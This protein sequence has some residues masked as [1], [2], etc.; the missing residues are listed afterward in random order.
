M[1]LNFKI[2]SIFI[3]LPL[4]LVF[5]AEVLAFFY[6]TISSM[7]KVIICITLLFPFWIK[8]KLPS[9]FMGFLCFFLPFF[10]FSFFNSFSSAAAMEEGVR[11]IF[12]IAILVYGYYI[13]SNLKLLVNS[14]VVFMV[15]NFVYQISN[16]VNYYIFDVDSQWFY[17]HHYAEKIDRHFY[18]PA[19][20]GGIMRATGLVGFFAAFGILNFVTYWL[21]MYYYNGKYKKIILLISFLGVFLS[22]SFKAIGFFILT[23]LIKFW[24]RIKYLLVLPIILL[25]SYLLIGDENRQTI[26]QAITA[27]LDF[28][29]TEGNSARSESYRVMFNEIKSFNM[30]GEGLGSFGGPASTKY[31]SPFYEKVNFNWYGLNNLDTTDTYFPHLFVEMGI[32]GGL[33]YLFLILSPII[34]KKRL[35]LKNAKILLILYGLL[36]IDSVFSYSLNNLAILSMTLLFVYPILKYKDDLN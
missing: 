23:L 1:K 13:R 34:I 26:S 10:I 6:P 14:L 11:Y 4:I 24:Y 20:V 28:Y 5:V 31:N 29:I 16:Y 30:V 8:I 3:L 7:L 19:T 12:P 36:F 21:S 2:S 33:S 22:L 18:K 35:N 25:G 17:L 27:R 15:L 9:S 32:L